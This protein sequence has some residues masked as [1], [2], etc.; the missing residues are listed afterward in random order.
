MHDK[1]VALITARGGSKGIPR[2]NIKIIAGKPLIAWTIEAAHRC[3]EL[4]RVIVSTDDLEIARISK[5]HGAEVPFLRPRELALDASSSVDAALHMLDWLAT[6]ECVRPELLLLLQPTSPLR[7]AEDIKTALALLHERD[8]NAVVSINAVPLP[9]SWL[10]VLE[11]GELLP[12]EPA[13]GTTRR[14]DSKVAYL[15]NGAIYLIKTDVLREQETFYPTR[16]FAYPMPTLRSLDIDD[17]DDFHLAELLL[18]EHHEN[19]PL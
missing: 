6:H 13:G 5:E 19:Q 17:M 18:K 10:K 15:P 14:Q 11:G 3:S 16:T 7:D 2:K 9:T 4:D 12:L 1:T 8:A